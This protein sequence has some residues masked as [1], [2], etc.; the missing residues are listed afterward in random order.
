MPLTSCLPHSMPPPP[1][2]PP[3]FECSGS[4]PDKEQLYITFCFNKF[5]K[6]QKKYNNNKKENAKFVVLVGDYGGWEMNERQADRL[7]GWLF[8]FNDSLRQCFSLYRVVFQREGEREE[9]R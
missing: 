6:Q 4:G 8:G 7:V 3:E 9:K 1:P 2:P 5:K